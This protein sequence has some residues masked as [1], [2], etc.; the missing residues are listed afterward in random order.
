MTGYWGIKKWNHL[1]RGRCSDKIR[2]LATLAGLSSRQTKILW[3]S[4]CQPEKL[5]TWE[6][7]NQLNTS[8]RTVRNEK[9]T[10]LILIQ[11][12]CE[13][14]KTDNVSGDLF[15]EMGE[16][17]GLPRYVLNWKPS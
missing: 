1:M 2:I 16:E 4:F 6:I 15:F 8:E 11:K 10:A 13:E 12:L 5:Q 9:R 17:A 3:L 14:Q 7:A